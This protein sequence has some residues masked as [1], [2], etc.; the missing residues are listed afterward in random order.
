MYTKDVYPEVILNATAPTNVFPRNIFVVLKLLERYN[1]SK[2]VKEGAK[3][4]AI[5]LPLNFVI[6]QVMPLSGYMP[7]SRAV[8]RY[9]NSVF[10]S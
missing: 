6:N 1:N 8:I 5:F 10:N 9:V 4:L 7:V 2:Y 3:M